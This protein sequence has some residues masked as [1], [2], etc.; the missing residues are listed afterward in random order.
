MKDHTSSAL[1]PTMGMAADVIKWRMPRLASSG[2][3]VGNKMSKHLRWRQAREEQRERVLAHMADSDWLEDCLG[4]YARK[5]AKGDSKA[6]VKGYKVRS[7]WLIKAVLEEDV[8][9]AVLGQHGA[10]LG[11]NQVGVVVSELR[12]G[13][14]ELSCSGTHLAASSGSGGGAYE[15]AYF[16]SLAASH[17]LTDATM[18]AF[19]PMHD[20]AATT[21]H[22]S[23]GDALSHGFTA[24]SPAAAGSG[25]GSQYAAK[26]TAGDLQLKLAVSGLYRPNSGKTTI[27]SMKNAYVGQRALVPQPTLARTCAPASRACMAWVVYASKL[28]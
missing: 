9:L 14:D 16:P 4:S 11:D 6:G 3:G 19:L 2:P 13:R 5:D 28:A 22:A 1:A 12:R 25:T 24:A 21:D 8:R 27:C 26:D 18:E 23:P 10:S 7:C 15:C 17:M 20:V